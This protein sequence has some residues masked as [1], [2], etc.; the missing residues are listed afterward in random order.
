[1]ILAGPHQMGL[2][3]LAFSSYVTVAVLRN[4]L[5]SPLE[6]GLFFFSVLASMDRPLA[7]ALQGLPRESNTAFLMRLVKRTMKLGAYVLLMWFLEHCVDP[8]EMVLLQL[9]LGVSLLW[10][11]GVTLKLKKKCIL[12]STFFL[13]LFPSIFFFCVCLFFFSSKSN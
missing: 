8:N 1:M 2:A 5:Y 10:R 4:I 3:I 13:Q 12:A 7:D 6:I 9:A 11:K